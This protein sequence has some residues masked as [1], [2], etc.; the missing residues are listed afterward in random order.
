MIGDA[1]RRATAVSL[2]PVS[3]DADSRAFRI[4]RSLAEEGF[5]SLVI[6]GRASKRRFWGTKIEV[7]SAGNQSAAA[8]PLDGSGAP[9]RN[10]VSALR[11]GRL[12]KVGELALYSGFRGYD[13]WRHCRQPRH[14]LPPADLYYLHSFELY[15]VVAPIASRLGAKV[16]Y[17]AHDFYRG[18]EPAERQSSFD[19]N[20]VRPFLNE[21]EDR[22][23]A[24]ANAVVT[25]SDGVADL[26]T[27]AF[28]RRPVV[29][30][31]CHDERL[32]RPVTRDLR[33]EL[34]LA[35]EDNLCVV[36]GN[37]KPGMAVTVAVEALAC[38]PDRFHLAFLGRGYDKAAPVL[39][40]ALVGR[41]IHFGRFAAPDEVVP[42]IRTAD[43]G[44]VIYEPY[45]DN[46]RSALPNGFFQII[47]AGL[48]LVRA[49]LTEIEAI[50]GDSQVGVC[51]TRL[52]P[53]A[54][55]NAIELCAGN[56][57][58]LGI[59]TTAL[60]RRL[61]WQIEATRLRSLVAELLDAPATSE[62]G[63]TVRSLPMEKNKA[64]AG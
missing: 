37:W 8:T 20:W 31:N 32:D 21:I 4:A 47:A 25:V 19:R 28:G 33:T 36:V 11:C 34:G 7:R 17:D 14:L 1:R 64:C 22:L 53:T 55:A 41:R 29:I 23:V 30:R 54:L 56:S 3:L 52:D 63:R 12:G 44:L 49:P 9:L 38:L 35:P 48:P 42:A 46:Y 10:A 62:H 57:E 43:M 5:R 61:R 16:I 2:T 59:N 39:S 50:I 60:A 40:S 24:D 58:A 26:M 45:S 15:R 6:E 18:I 13:W 51:L 27:D